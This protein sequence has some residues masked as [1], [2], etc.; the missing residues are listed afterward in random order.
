[1]SQPNRAEDPYS[2]LVPSGIVVLEGAV[3]IMEPYDTVDPKIKVVTRE[4]L[5][6][7]SEVEAGTFSL[8]ATSIDLDILGMPASALI[9]ELT[10]QSKTRRESSKGLLFGAIDCA[11]RF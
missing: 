9:N 11:L 7:V 8:V 10:D 2:A 4:L 3:G 5:Q 1:M 6:E